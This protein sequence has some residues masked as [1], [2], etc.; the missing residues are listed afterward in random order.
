[1]KYCQWWQHRS[2]AYCTILS[3]IAAQSSWWIVSVEDCVSRAIIQISRQRRASAYATVY[4]DQR[5]LC[6]LLFVSQSSL[7]I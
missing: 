1:M 5:S 3:T 4:A 2:L 6:S 7:S